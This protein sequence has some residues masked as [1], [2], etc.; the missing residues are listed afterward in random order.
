MNARRPPLRAV[1]FD[2]DGTLLDTAPDMGGALNELRAEAGLAPLDPGTIRPHVSH[3]STGL[4][5]LAFGD[6]GEAAFERLRARFLEIYRG[7][8]ARETRPFEGG[9][10][11]LA[12][13]E[14]RGL[15]WGVVTNKPAWLTEPL[16][17][18]LGLDRRASCIVS[19]DTLAE[20]K[21]HPRPLQFAAER[22]ACAA[23]SCVYVGDAERDM[24]AARAAGMIGLVAGF[25]YIGAEAS[26]Q[27][28][29]ADGWLHDPC[30]LIAWLDARS[31]VAG[32][33][34]CAAPSR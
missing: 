10:Q 2:L 17:A 5:S 13:L 30:D 26:A 6:P 27:R 25:G 16:L 3:G 8:I 1:L 32:P 29:P 4:V 7:R 15:P 9:A 34:P 33:S 21:P 20:R 23:A 31:P 22:L 28:W 11:M 24:L 18:A 12:E 19:G 14:R